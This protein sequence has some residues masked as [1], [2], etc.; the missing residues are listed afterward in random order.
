VIYRKGTYLTFLLSEESRSRV[1]QAVPPSFS[2][3]LA[4]HVTIDFNPT[5]EKLDSYAQ[6]F[7][8]EDKVSVY[9][10]ARGDGVECLGVQIG[11][12]RERP[13]GSFYHVTLSV[14]PPHKPVESNELKSKIEL[15]RGFINLRGMFTLLK[16]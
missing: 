3:V 9:G 5:Q 8:S 16:K 11:G 4:H 6:L 10:I 7:K 12:E 15:I 13:D 2:R 1:L 14:E